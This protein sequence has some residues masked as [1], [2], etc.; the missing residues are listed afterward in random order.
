MLCSLSLSLS[1]ADR[2]NSV[3]PLHIQKW[4]CSLMRH[5][6]QPRPLPLSRRR[7]LSLVIYLYWLAL[8]FHL[9][10]GSFNNVCVSALCTVRGR[11]STCNCC[12]A[13]HTGLDGCSPSTVTSRKTILLYNSTGII[14]FNLCFFL[15]YHFQCFKYAPQLQ[16]NRYFFQ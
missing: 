14:H 10:T 15:L 5:N 13:G 2:C 1:C 8:Q 6:F 4:C 11:G 7:I 16:I 9:N 12:A 3:F